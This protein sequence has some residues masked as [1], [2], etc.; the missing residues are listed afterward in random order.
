MQRRVLQHGKPDPT[1]L[2]FTLYRV[3]GHSD[4]VKYPKVHLNIGYG[5]QTQISS[6]SPTH[7]LHT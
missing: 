3:W 6:L 7:H 2:P 4:P 5:V 1:K